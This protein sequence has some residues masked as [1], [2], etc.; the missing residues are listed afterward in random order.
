M[1]RTYRQ[2]LGD[3]LRRREYRGWTGQVTRRGYPSADRGEV[4]AELFAPGYQFRD[5]STDRATIYLVRPDG[6][7]AYDR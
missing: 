2:Q 3:L 6:S 7:V 4:V 5:P 1:T